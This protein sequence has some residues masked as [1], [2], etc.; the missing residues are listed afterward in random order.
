MWNVKILKGQQIYNGYC[1]IMNNYSILKLGFV[2]Y[3]YP[4]RLIS[5]FFKCFED[6]LISYFFKIKCNLTDDEFALT[7]LKARYVIKKRFKSVFY[8]YKACRSRFL[9]H[10]R[11]FLSRLSLKLMRFREISSLLLIKMWSHII[12][13]SNLFRHS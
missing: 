7:Y 13:F 8:Y 12:D 2:K 3:F 1:K 10:L 4:P 9:K 6:V 11:D 5:I